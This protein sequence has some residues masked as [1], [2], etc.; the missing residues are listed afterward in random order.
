MDKKLLSYLIFC[1]S[2]FV[3]YS[4]NREKGERKGDRDLITG[5]GLTLNRESPPED[6]AKFLIMALDHADVGLLCKLVAVEHESE[7]LKKIL[8]V[9][10]G[11][12]SF[13]AEDVESLVVAGWMATYAFFEKGQTFVTE[14]KTID[15]ECIVMARGIKPT[16][17]KT[18]EIRMVKENGWWKVMGGFREK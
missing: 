16:G 17:E 12:V 7:E 14:V 5:Y 15:G 6:V 18:M 11:S 1:A 8:R 3:Y 13:K 4:P 2:F 10:E 9:R